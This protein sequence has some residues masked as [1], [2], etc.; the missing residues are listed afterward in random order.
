MRS[1]RWR[2]ARAS[3]WVPALR[4]AQIAR[5]AAAWAAVFIALAPAV[6]ACGGGS[7]KK[8]SEGAGPGTTPKQSGGGSTARTGPCTLLTSAEVQAALGGPFKPPTRNASPVGGAVQ[9]CTWFPQ[10]GS[11][12]LGFVQV[13]VAD[14]PG[15]GRAVF[16]GGK[17]ATAGAKDA[18]GIGDAAYSSKAGS[19]TKITSLK[20]ETVISVTSV[21]E[22]SAMK[23]AK[24]VL[25]RL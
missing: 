20:G 2:R 4:G 15:G 25:D 10:A 5:R 18:S 19:N 13:S 12:P 9:V 14:F 1:S 21:D 11:G 22:A 6:A 17:R 16:G 3:S 24:A 8:P 7:D 23:L